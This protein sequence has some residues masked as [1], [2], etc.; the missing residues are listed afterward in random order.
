MSTRRQGEWRPRCT[1]GTLR[2]HRRSQRR[3]SLIATCYQCLRNRGLFYRI[4]GLHG[5]RLLLICFTLS[6]TLSPAA[7]LYASDELMDAGRASSIDFML[8]N[9]IRRGLIAGGVVAV[10]NHNGLLYSTS[11]GRLF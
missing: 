5:V 2:S 9:A 11:L 7:L 1:I 6:I 10:G 8:D 3:N 4:P